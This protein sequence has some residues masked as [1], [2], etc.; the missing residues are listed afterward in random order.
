MARERSHDEDDD[1][2]DDGPPRRRSRNDDDDSDRGGRGA[3]PKNYL[4]ESIL[5]TVFCC[6]PFGIVAIVNA[7]AVN[8]AWASG[9]S[10]GAKR[11]AA[12]AAKWCKWSL[13]IGLVWIVTAIVVNVFVIG[14]AG[15]LNNK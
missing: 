1:D 14:A 7:A 12:Q 10:R 4:V 3:P 9:D 6:L 5:V 8:S 11:A 2:R 15:A 13:I